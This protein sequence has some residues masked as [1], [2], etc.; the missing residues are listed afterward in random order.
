MAQQ[1]YTGIIMIAALGG[2]AYYGYQQGWFSALFPTAAAPA[3]AP[4]ASAAAPVVT[5]SPSQSAPV[6]A[7]T[8]AASVT[9]PPAP[10]TS[11]AT[12]EQITSALQLIA[13]AGSESNFNAD[14]WGFY[15]NKLGWP[16]IPGDISTAAFFPNGRPAN[17]SDYTQY[18]ALQFIIALENAGGATP[19][20]LESITNSLLAGNGLGNY[21]GIPI[22]R[23]HGGW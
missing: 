19:A 8:P 5:S 15:W 14:Q 10:S 17:T 23:I 16:A 7:S 13:A 1:D 21:G 4:V 22:R 6:V 20:M 9:T 3:P 2:V 12:A 18:S 11:N